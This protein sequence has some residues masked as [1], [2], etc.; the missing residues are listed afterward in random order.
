MVGANVGFVMNQMALGKNFFPRLIWFSLV[1]I[2]LSP[3][4]IIFH[5]P[6]KEVE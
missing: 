1:R 6:I 5:S 4:V 3:S 2:I